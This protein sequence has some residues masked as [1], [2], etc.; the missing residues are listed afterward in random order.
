MTHHSVIDEESNLEGVD[1]VTSII[2][3]YYD[4]NIFLVEDILSLNELEYFELSIFNQTF[5][6]S[7][8]YNYPSFRVEEHYTQNDMIEIY[9]STSIPEYKLLQIFVNGLKRRGVELLWLGSPIFF[10]QL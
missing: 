9:H 6:S 8:I 1:P 5:L 10:G 4:N 3:N 2:Q 7:I